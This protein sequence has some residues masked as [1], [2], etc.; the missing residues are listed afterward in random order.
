M[1]LIFKR[2]QVVRVLVLLISYSLTKN[3]KPP[4]LISKLLKPLLLRAIPATL[5]FENVYISF[6]IGPNVQ[7]FEGAHLCYHDICMIW[8][9]WL[10]V[11]KEEHGN[12]LSF[13]SNFDE[14]LL[15]GKGWIE[16]ISPWGNQSFTSLYVWYLSV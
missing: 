8:S 12:I 4:W 3:T 1:H 9:L 14:Y 7:K 2:Y 10:I 5:L 11:Y 13:H 16:V 15:N 6:L